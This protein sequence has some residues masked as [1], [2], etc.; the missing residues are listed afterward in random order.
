MEGDREAVLFGELVG[1]QEGL[2][3]G[4]ALLIRQV[5]L[6]AHNFVLLQ[7]RLYCRQLGRDGL[8]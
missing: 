6:Q 8:F 1:R 3:A 4:P 2:V 5:N 7:I